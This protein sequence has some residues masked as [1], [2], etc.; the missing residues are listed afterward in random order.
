MG[1]DELRIAGMVPFSTVDWPDR[2]AASL[3]LQGCPWQCPYCHNSAI[4]DP[5]APGQVPWNSVEELLSRRAGLLDGVVFSGGEALMQGST[6]GESALET[7]MARV[8]QLGYKTGLHTAGAFPKRLARLL[9]QQLVDWVGLDIKALPGQYQ[10]ATGSPAAAVR[11]EQSLSVLNARAE[12]D[13]NFEWEV[14]LTLW[15][16]LT[17]F[18][19]R[20]ASSDQSSLLDY[21]QAVA[22]WAR[23]RGARRFALQQYRVPQGRETK[24]GPEVMWDQDRARQLIGALGFDQVEIR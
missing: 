20:A 11:A 15:P 13:P 6:D 17:A 5:R 23:E 1:A 12:V 16:A 18:G 2:I 21:A 7:A 24:G 4:L 3:F 22:K 9:G 19:E 8:R 14:R 10:M